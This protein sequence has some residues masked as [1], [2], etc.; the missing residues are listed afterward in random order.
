MVILYHHKTKYPS[1]AKDFVTKTHKRKKTKQ[2]LLSNNVY[3]QRLTPSNRRF[4]L[5]LGL[6]L[7]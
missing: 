4:L 2:I 6:K 1:F 7:K 3:T 5:S